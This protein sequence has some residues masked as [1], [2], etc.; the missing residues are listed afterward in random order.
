MVFPAYAQVGTTINLKGIRPPEYANKTLP[1]ERT[2]YGKINKSRKFIQNAFVRFN[3]WF[4][5][6]QILNQTL[7]ETMTNNVDDYSHLLRFFP[8]DEKILA[9]NK[10]LDSVI[11]HATAGLLLHDLRNTY[12]DELYYL[13]G[14]AYAYEGKFDSAQQV[15]Q[16][17]NYV[18]ARKDDGYYIPIG[19][20]LSSGSDKRFFI[21]SEEKSGIGKNSL[22]NINRRND[23][24]VWLARIYVERRDYAQAEILLQNLSRDAHFPARLLPLLNETKAYFYYRQQQ[25]DSSATYLSKC[26]FSYDTKLLKARRA[27]LT[28]QMYALSGMDSSAYQ[29]FDI[30]KNLSNDA[31]IAIYAEKNKM[32][33]TNKQKNNLGNLQGELTGMAKKNKYYLYK[34]LV[35]YNEAELANENQGDDKN[36]IAF[37]RQA[38]QANRNMQPRNRDL[39]N[40][41]FYLWGNI[42]YNNNRFA[43]ASAYYDSVSVNNIYDSVSREQLKMRIPPLQKIAENSKFIHAQDSL[44]D[45]ANMPE[46]QRMSILR[47]AARRIRKEIDQREAS[48]EDSTSSMYNNNP[49]LN[50]SQQQAVDLFSQNSNS[51]TLWYFNNDA[52]KTSGYQLFKQK[53]GNR[54]NVDN[55]QR[56]S[57]ISLNSAARAG[58]N[59]DSSLLNSEGIL[60]LDSANITAED[61]LADLPMSQEAKAATQNGISQHMLDN[62]KILQNSLENFKGAIFTYDSLMSKYPQSKQVPEALY[63]MFICYSLLGNSAQ[64][65]IAKNKLLTNYP[66]DT[67]I[68]KLT[69]PKDLLAVS[70]TSLADAATKEYN[71]IYNLFLDGKFDEA[72]QRKKIADNIYGKFYWTPQLLYIEAIYHVSKKEDT[73][74]INRLDYLVKNFAASPIVPQAKTMMDVLKNRKKIENYLLALNIS[75]EDYLQD[76]TLAKLEDAADR[77]NQSE[78]RIALFRKN[79]FVE[80]PI[81]HLKML[82]PAIVGVSDKKYIPVINVQELIQAQMNARQQAVE[83]NIAANNNAQN[84][85]SDTAQTAPQQPLN[86]IPAEDNN[87]AAANNQP[88]NQQNNAEQSQPNNVANN[89]VPAENNNVVTS[90]NQQKNVVQTTPNTTQT[91]PDNIANNHVPTENNNQNAQQSN[92]TNV[93]KTVPQQAPKNP[94]TNN[95]P[96]ETNIPQNA[97][98]VTINGF[99]FDNSAPQYVAIALNNVAPVFASEAGNA[100]NRYNLITFPNRRYNVR[101]QLAGDYTLVLIGPFNNSAEA[102]SYLSTIRQDVATEIIPWITPD[103]YSFM[104]IS[105]ANSD[106]IQSNADMDKYKASAKIAGE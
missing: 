92:P 35:Y 12:V 100:F 36:T 44:L 43:S 7:E 11:E 6:N 9:N 41:I 13:T 68:K 84:I 87:V 61:L 82:P 102:Q 60:K 72:N 93:T 98:V 94:P 106:K 14:K 10:M 57:A 8:Y 19:S 45:L 18:F 1:A 17:M 3:Y 4:N 83:N 42:E 69:A 5:A 62:G 47:E 70:H 56:A 53:F 2:P 26:N 32:A 64:A 76:N 99:T 58:Q 31:Q 30:A 101:S 75:P 33:I 73:V 105:P 29:Y 85:P 71:E 39:Q 95:I 80:F 74:A 52:L 24:L 54:P 66:Q 97:P 104:K 40:K 91:Q 55:W 88:N 59:A 49:N 65:E 63:N 81:T 90:D 89:K 27:Y 34:D 51:S 78:R 79:Q 86:N 20:N 67:L 16:Y 23:A 22:N 28:A 77:L 96:T 50:K 46:K 15:F 48:A 38:I 25:Y 21:S 37:L 103:K